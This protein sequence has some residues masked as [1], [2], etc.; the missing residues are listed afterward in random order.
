MI[1]AYDI[2]HEVAVIGTDIHGL[3][4]GVHISRGAPTYEVRYWDD[5]IRRSGWFYDM[6]LEPYDKL[7]IIEPTGV[8]VKRPA[9]DTK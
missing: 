1:V 9:K 7:A 3:V 4:V 6:E 5:K 2:G 8:F